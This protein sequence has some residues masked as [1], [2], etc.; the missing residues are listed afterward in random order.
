ME[1]Y[2][3]FWRRVGAA[4]LDWV[5]LAP[6]NWGVSVVITLASASPT[7]LA[8]AVPGFISAV[9]YILMHYYQGQ[10]LGK[11][12]ARVR[13][14]DDSEKPLN[15]GQAIIRSLPQLFVPM[16]AVSASTA[17]PAAES[18]A[19]WAAVIQGFT[20]VF[21]VANVIVCL[22]NE[23]NRALHDFIAG[24]IVVRTDV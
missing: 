10:T 13:V 6:V 23:R 19:V 15:F 24:T 21:S 1:K 7:T 17:D 3:T 5:V 11:M 8:W 12:V 20:F 9:Y 18:I 2:H 4:F 16:F 14:L 22:A